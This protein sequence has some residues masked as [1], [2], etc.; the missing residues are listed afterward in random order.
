MVPYKTIS[1]FPDFHD[2]LIRILND[3]DD[4]NEDENEEEEEKDIV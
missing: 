4:E 2:S 1:F 3:E